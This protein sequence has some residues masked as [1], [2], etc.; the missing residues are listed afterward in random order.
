MVDQELNEN[1]VIRMIAGKRIVKLP[2][3]TGT[4]GKLMEQ[5]DILEQG[6]IEDGSALMCAICLQY[7]DKEDQVTSL[8]C[9]KKH[10]FHNNC[11]KMAL[12]QKK[13]CPI[14][15]KPV[16]IQVATQATS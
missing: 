9:H 12:E 16:W 2:P 5:G 14:C 11:I 7:F 8:A 4:F 13:Q 3:K 1:K 6:D 15:R 10:V